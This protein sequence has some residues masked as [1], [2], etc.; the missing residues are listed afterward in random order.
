MGSRGWDVLM[1]SVSTGSGGGIPAVPTRN[2][3]LHIPLRRPPVPVDDLEA[4]F[5]G[6]AVLRGHPPQQQGA[7]VSSRVPQELGSVPKPGVHVLALRVVHHGLLV[8]VVLVPDGHD[9][10]AGRDAV[11]EAQ[12]AG[13]HHAGTRDAPQLGGVADTPGAVGWRREGKGWVI[14]GGR[15]CPAPLCHPTSPVPLLLTPSSQGHSG[16]W[17]RRAEP[18]RKKRGGGDKWG[19]VR[20]GA[21]L[22]AGLPAGKR[23]QLD[24]KGKGPKSPG[25]KGEICPLSPLGARFL[26]PLP[27]SKSFLHALAVPLLRGLVRWHL[28]WGHK[29]GHEDEPLQG[30]RGHSHGAGGRGQEVSGRCAAAPDG[31]R[32]P[33][34]PRT[35]LIHPAPCH[36]LAPKPPHPVLLSPGGDP[37]R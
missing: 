4:E 11:G 1:G 30:G 3:Q 21:M 29:A 16:V 28:T 23:H 18:S 12:R 31:R 5:V 7:V 26:A 36:L 9:A 20:P 6:P 13:E 10:F 27:V 25:R 8:A 24:S 22:P 2:S 19:R 14:R 33:K 34:S 32:V 17:E 15:W 35:T 37:T